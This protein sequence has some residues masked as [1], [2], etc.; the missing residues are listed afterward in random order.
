MADP[1]VVRTVLDQLGA[2]GIGLSIDDFGTGYSSLAYLRDLPVDEVKI[3]RS[4]V[5][6]MADGTSDQ[7][8]VRS[9]IDL[10]HHLGLQVVA[11]GVEDEDTLRRLAE[12][13][14]DRAQGY[15]ISRPLP[16]NELAAW[17]K[18]VAGVA[19]DHAPA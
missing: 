7:V 6:G 3:D 11:E 1:R 2:M 17:A 19:V 15:W 16:A 9:V 10:G 18:T 13:D 12:H 14:C 8:I 4:F 5:S